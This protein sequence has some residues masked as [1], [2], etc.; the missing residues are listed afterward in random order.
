MLGRDAGA[1]V[2]DDRLD[3]AVDQ[4][5]DAQAPAAGHGL[6]GVQQQV[7]EDLLQFAGIAVDGRQLVGQVEIDD[8]SARS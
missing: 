8:E 3:V 2:G 7:E 4:R 1:G 6:L 5:G